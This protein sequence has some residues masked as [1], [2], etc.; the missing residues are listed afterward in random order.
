MEFPALIF[1]I[2]FI[3]ELYTVSALQLATMDRV[4]IAESKHGNG[5]QGSRARVRARACAC[6]HPMRMRITA[7]SASSWGKP[8]M[9]INLI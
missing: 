2:I 8:S 7:I 3:V 9:L 6:V 5:R 1:F 4:M